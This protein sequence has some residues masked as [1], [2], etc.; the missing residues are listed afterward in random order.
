MKLT[1]SHSALKDFENCALSYY[2]NRILKDVPRVKGEAAVWGERV[3][4]D[5][6]S[7]VKDGVPLPKHLEHF[8]PHL[9]K[10]LGM[11]ARC[12]WKVCLNEELKPTEWMAKDAWL[13][14]VIDLYVPTQ[15]KVCVVVDY[16]TGKH[17]TEFDQL[18]L[19]ALFVF[20]Q[21][22]DIEEVRAAF[23]WTQTNELDTAIYRRA[24]I[25]D[26]WAKYL[27]KIRRVHQAYESNVWP[28]KPSG[29]CSYCGFKPKCNYAQKGRR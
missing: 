20:A 6:E 15:P 4:K 25:N 14:G 8:E 13:R 7:R 22:P 24:N 26:L 23:F 9:N 16:K 3:H 18:E 12:E 2:H 1:H 28:A 27:A 17:R 29:L 11:N 19:S 21:E 10:F 5:F